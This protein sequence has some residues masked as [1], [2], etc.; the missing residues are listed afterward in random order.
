MLDIQ[1]FVIG[2]ASRCNSS[3]AFATEALFLLGYEH[4][5]ADYRELTMGINFSQLLLTLFSS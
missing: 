1:Y 3:V 5:L 4:E 2:C